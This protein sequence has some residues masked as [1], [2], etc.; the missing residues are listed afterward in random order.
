MKNLSTSPRSILTSSSDA[1]STLKSFSVR[2]FPAFGDERAVTMI[3]FALVIPVLILFVLAFVDLVRVIA[4][5]G[6]LVH[7]AEQTLQVASTMPNFDV[8]IRTSDPNSPEYQRFML[9]RQRI[10]QDA[11]KLPLQTLLTDSGTPSAAQLIRFS[12]EDPAPSGGGPAPAPFSADVAILR[13]GEHVKVGDVT[14]TTYFDHE[15]YPFPGTGINEPSLERLLK[16][17]PI[18]IEIRARVSTFTPAIGTITTKGVAQGFRDPI[19]QGPMPDE[20]LAS[21]TL[22]TPWPSPTPSPTAYPFTDPTPRPTPGGCDASTSGPFTAAKLSFSRSLP[23]ESISSGPCPP[24]VK[25]WI[26]S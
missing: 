1:P 6:I 8:D 9:A 19:P 7:V 20:V 14:S 24:D 5:Q 17:Q 11:A 25:S 3:E 26:G 21:T 13:P 23:N 2:R 16:T 18:I 15:T 12:Y 22:T 10:F 4:V